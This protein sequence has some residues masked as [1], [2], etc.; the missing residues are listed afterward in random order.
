MLAGLVT[1]IPSRLWIAFDSMQVV[2]EF[3][4]ERAKGKDA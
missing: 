1:N 3:N 2:S 4:D